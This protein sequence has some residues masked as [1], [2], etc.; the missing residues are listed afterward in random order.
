M[1]LWSNR[2]T[3]GMA[4]TQDDKK[5]IVMRARPLPI[6]GIFLPHLIPL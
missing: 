4:I 1:D 6:E 5:G 3:F 2:R